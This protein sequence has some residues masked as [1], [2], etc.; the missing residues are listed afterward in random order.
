MEQVAVIG[1]GTMGHSIAIAV[2]WAKQPV[3]LYGLSEQELRQAQQEI[4]EKVARMVEEGVLDDAATLLS[5][6]HYR[7]DLQH[8]V[9]V[10]R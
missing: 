5:C 6:I 9:E 8:A 10:R 2:A 7:Q 4:T 3:E 1:T